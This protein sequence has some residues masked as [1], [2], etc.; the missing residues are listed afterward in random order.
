MAAVARLCAY[1]FDSATPFDGALVAAIERMEIS[2]G[3]TLLDALFVT[4]DAGSGDIVAIDLA[5]AAADSTFAAL[6]DFRLDPARRLAISRRTLD[7]HRGGVPP[8]LT[9]Q[10][11]A[12]LD[13]DAAMLLVLHRGDTPTTLRDAVERCHGTA[14]G[15]E[16]VAAGTIAQL[17]EAVSALLAR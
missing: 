2:D 3:G 1:R 16:P 12:T 6:L 7:E 13:R 4:H 5:T 11:A 17:A 8:A 14:I 15:E 10:V 9:R